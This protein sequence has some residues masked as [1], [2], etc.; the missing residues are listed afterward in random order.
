MFCSKCGAPLSDEATFCERCGSERRET[1]IDDPNANPYAYN[2]DTISEA[3]VNDYLVQNII[4]TICCCNPILGLLGIFLSGLALGAY[5]GGERR[6]AEAYATAARLV[7]F[8][9]VFWDVILWALFILRLLR[10][11]WFFVPYLENFDA[12]FFYD[13]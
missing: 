3:P 6:R 5:N 11:P 13:H 9:N 8:A 1:S 4:A 7:F 2:R 12:S 10:D